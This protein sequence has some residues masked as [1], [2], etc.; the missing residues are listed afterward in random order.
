MQFEKLS[1]AARAA[2][3]AMAVSDE[4]LSTSTHEQDGT[5]EAWRASEIKPLTANSFAR[6]TSDW[7]RAIYQLFGWSA[8]A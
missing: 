8:T 2:G 3:Y 4:L 5:A 6:E 7:R 1:K